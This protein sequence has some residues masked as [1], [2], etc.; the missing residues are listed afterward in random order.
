MAF[1]N[2]QEFKLFAIIRIL[3]EAHLI[4]SHTTRDETLTVVL[5]LSLVRKAHKVGGLVSVESRQ[6]VGTALFALG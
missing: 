5:V 2:N 6:L 4:L 3:S 1:I